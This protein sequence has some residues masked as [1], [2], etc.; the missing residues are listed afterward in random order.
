MG[1]R[2]LADIAGERGE[3]WQDVLD[4]R[5]IEKAYESG[6]EVKAEPLI[7]SI[8]IGGAQALSSIIQQIGQG[9]I[10]PTQAETILV[11]VFGMTTEAARKIAQDAGVKKT[12]QPASIPRDNS[13]APDEQQVSPD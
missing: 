8:G 9:L 3:D 2:T 1:I 7:T 5:K 4:Q 12:E 13:Q 6:G 10:T 11:S